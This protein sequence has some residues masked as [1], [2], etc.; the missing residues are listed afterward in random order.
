MPK[1]K[2]KHT[3]LIETVD[4]GEYRLTPDEREVIITWSSSENTMQVV[5]EIPAFA[6]MLDQRGY[7]PDKEGFYHVPV[8]KMTIRKAE[9]IK[10][11]ITAEHKAKLVVAAAKARAARGK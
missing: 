7:T 10:R 1:T 5:A 4:G 3:S 6:R 8:S 2:Q 11:T 9:K